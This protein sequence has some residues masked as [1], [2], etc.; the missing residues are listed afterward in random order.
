M[1]L[2]N[3]M[4]VHSMQGIRN[5]Y[6]KWKDFSITKKSVTLFATLAVTG[7]GIFYRAAWMELILREKPV[8]KGPTRISKPVDY[9][10]DRSWL[11][12]R[13]H[14]LTCLYSGLWDELTP[15]EILTLCGEEDVC[16]QVHGSKQTNTNTGIQK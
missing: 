9:S 13:D 8:G 14:Q 15:K 5:L 1:I 11:G 12:C 16:D 3:R 10:S 6:N 7:F 2:L 4:L